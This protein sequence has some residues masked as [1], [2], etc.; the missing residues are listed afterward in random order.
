[1]QLLSSGP[2]E[3]STLK[4][5]MGGAEWKGWVVSAK[6][7]HSFNVD[8]WV[9]QEVGREGEGGGRASCT[10]FRFSDKKRIDRFV[11]GPLTRTVDSRVSRGFLA[12]DTHAAA[13]VHCALEGWSRARA[14]P[15]DTPESAA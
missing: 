8:S 7:V 9:A 2:L 13:R 11:R 15:R 1:M 12:R 10:K 5:S 4:L 3:D 14:K 6:A